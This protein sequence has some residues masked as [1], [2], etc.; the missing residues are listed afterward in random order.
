M[1]RAR[2]DVAVDEEEELVGADGAVVHVGLNAVLEDG[3]RQ[4][5]YRGALHPP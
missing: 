1:T 4:S 2:L 3:E 5:R